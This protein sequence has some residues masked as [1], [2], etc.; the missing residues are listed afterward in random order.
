[1]STPLDRRPLDTLDG[2]EVGRQV[3]L[4]AAIPDARHL[5]PAV[6]PS[7]FEI[8]AAGYRGH[9][10]QLLTS[11]SRF[12][13]TVPEG[14][15]GIV[16][17]M[18]E[19]GD[20]AA[21]AF[22][23]KTP[24]SEKIT[25]AVCWIHAHH[26]VNHRGAPPLPG[27]K[28]KTT[29][30]DP[31]TPAPATVE[32][33]SMF[34][35]LTATPAP[36]PAPVAAPAPVAGS[37]DAMLA[38]IVD[39]RVGARVSALEA[40]LANRPAGTSVHHVRINNADPVALTARPHVRLPHVLARASMRKGNGG[41]FNVLMVGDAGT[42]KSTIA[43]HVAEAL[44]LSFRAIC[45]SGGL[46]EGALVGRL[47]P[48]LTTGELVYTP[49]PLVE[50]FRDGGVFLLDELDAADENVLL[51]INAMIDAPV[52]HTPTGEEI[53]RSPSFVLLGGANT[54]GTGASRIYNGRTQLDG[55]FLNRWF[56]V[57]VDYDTE[58][59]RTLCACLEIADRIQ[60]ARAVIRTR[61]LRRWLTTRDILKADALVGQLGVT[62][63]DALR[64]ITEGWTD[65]DRALLSL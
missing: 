9:I 21:V 11:T 29:P 10:D 36:L 5:I 57:P 3:K 33:S 37:L 44:G 25:A 24:K 26:L 32:P 7:V 27:E 52:W 53:P 35:T 61:N 50:A 45:C 40:E 46:T 1:M 63:A 64:E 23:W 30:A 62:V 59:E 31:T 38:A 17:R 49:G 65:E 55:A 60:K 47:T 15:R 8:E 34:Q 42:G 51:A 58:L 39:A 14:T 19:N 12:A 4:G 28:P 16:L 13:V 2:I 43:A 54:Y 41:R 56:N 6:S 22:V 48:N 18:H 20:S